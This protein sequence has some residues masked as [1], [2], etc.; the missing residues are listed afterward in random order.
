MKTREY[1]SDLTRLRTSVTR[2]DDFEADLGIFRMDRKKELKDQEKL[3][4]SWI[5]DAKKDLRAQLQGLETHQKKLLEDLKRSKIW[6][7]I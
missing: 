5:A 3:T 4:K 1:D 2:V 6:K 7:R